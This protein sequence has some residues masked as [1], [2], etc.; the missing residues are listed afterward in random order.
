MA[1]HF[2]GNWGIFTIAATGENLQ[3]LSPDSRSDGD[4]DWSPD[5]QQLVFGNVLEPLEARAIY[6]L[7]LRMHKVVALPESKGYFSPRWSPDG[8]FIV[9][10]RSDNQH[11]DTFELAS[12]RWQH[13]TQVAG[14]YPSWSH[15]GNHVYFVSTGS[16]DRI[17][18]R[19]GIRDRVLEPLANLAAVE[20]GPFIMGDWVGLG[21][22]DSPLA[23]RNLTTEDIY[24][25]DLST[26]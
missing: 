13:L 4:P 16:S 20:R 15:D 14:G 17:I 12:K 18:F 26:R 25:W 2:G 11:L 19:I 23:V 24:S 6:I 7:D 3:P 10:I 5:G 22:D 21:P 1:R 8:R 9:A